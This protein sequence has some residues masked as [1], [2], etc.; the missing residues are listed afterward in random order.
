MLEIEIP[1][2]DASELSSLGGFMIVRLE[3]ISS[4]DV[5]NVKDFIVFWPIG[6]LEAHG[7]HLPLGTDGFQAEYV[8]KEIGKHLDIV[9]L[10]TLWYGNVEGLA[11]YPGS[12]SLQYETLKNIVID[13]LESLWKANFRKVVIVSGHA[14][15]THMSAIRHGAKEIVKRYPEMKILVLSDYD[16]AYELLGKNV[17]EDDGHGGLIETSRVMDIKPE[18]VHLDKV[19]KDNIFKY[20]KFLIIPDYRVYYKEGYRGYPTKASKE[21][22]KEIN[23]Y[24]VKRL[25]ETLKEVFSL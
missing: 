15:S 7:P 25:L 3:E 2:N 8:V 1:I 6:V 21:L 13:V 22:G 14:G 10:P 12:I 18:L 20:P 5:E 11:S 16:F 9:I 23:D 24:I 17:P 4:Y 19:K